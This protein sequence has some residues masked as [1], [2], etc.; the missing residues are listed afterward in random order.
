M[1]GA[2]RCAHCKAPVARPSAEQE[3]ANADYWRQYGG[4]GEDGG[5]K[6]CAKCHAK[7]MA[8]WEREG[9]HGVQ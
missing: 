5:V 7:V 1:T 6:L 4:Y 9:K 8:W 3:K 2:E